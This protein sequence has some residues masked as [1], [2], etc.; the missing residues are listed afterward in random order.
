MAGGQLARP[1]RDHI[2]KL[3]GHYTARPCTPYTQDS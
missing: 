1:D 3:N 2:E